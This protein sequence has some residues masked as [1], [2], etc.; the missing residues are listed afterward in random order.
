MED[1]H[2][3]LKITNKSIEMKRVQFIGGI[4]TNE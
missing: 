3:W 2:I 4:S 1:S